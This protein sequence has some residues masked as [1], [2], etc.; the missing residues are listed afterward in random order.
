MVVLLHFQERDDGLLRSFVTSGVCSCS[1]MASHVSRG[2]L[3]NSPFV[4]LLRITMYGSPQLSDTDAMVLAAVKT[5]T[6]ERL[7][8]L[9]ITF[10]PQQILPRSNCSDDWRRT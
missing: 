7:L 1:A 2:H 10:R 3:V 8:A 6:A 4:S 5:Y 9:K